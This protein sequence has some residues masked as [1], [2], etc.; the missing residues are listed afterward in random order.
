METVPAYCL[1]L[2]SMRIAVAVAHGSDLLR[3]VADRRIQ[4]ISPHGNMGS[5]TVDITVQVYCL[6][7]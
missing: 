7:G 2:A 6:S 5:V 3:L 4:Y 1:R